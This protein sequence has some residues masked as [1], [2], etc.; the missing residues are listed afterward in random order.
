M[1]IKMLNKIINKKSGFTLIELV[2]YVSLVSVLVLGVASFWNVIRS[3]G[4]K[5]KSVSA[6]EEQGAFVSDIMNERIRQ[7]THVCTPTS[8]GDT[9]HTLD[10]DTNCTVHT[11]S[12]VSLAL[13]IHGILILTEG[14]QDYSLTDERVSMPSSSINFTKAQD[15]VHGGAESVNYTFV[16]QS[17]DYSSSSP[18][19][20]EKTFSGGGVLRVY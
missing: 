14:G 9:A 18:F 11:G 3:I 17:K 19:S 5:N 1:K 15:T 7:A 12:E 16:M 10:L 13:D 6:V 20:Y 2:L 4:L 8:A